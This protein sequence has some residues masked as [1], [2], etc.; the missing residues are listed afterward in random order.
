MQRNVCYNADMEK[1]RYKFEQL[2]N[3]AARLDEAL[4]L[5]D[6]PIKTDAVIQRF[7]FTTELFW[8]FLKILLEYDRVNFTPSPRETIRAAKTSG[9]LPSDDLW[10]QLIDDRNIASHTYND[11][12]AQ[13]VYNNIKNNYTAMFRE[14]INDYA[15]TRS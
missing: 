6:S 5:P 3:A 8:K 13:E 1:V 2:Q 4:A 10:M 7:E 12:K 15:R 14:F 9:Y 11:T